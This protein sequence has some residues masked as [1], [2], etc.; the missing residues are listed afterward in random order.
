[1]SW[2]QIVF[3]TLLVAVLLFLSLFY[4]W[5]QVRALRALRQAPELPPE[6]AR[7]ERTKAWRRLVSCGLTLALA[8]LLAGLLTFLEDRAQELA[9]RREAVAAGE[10][11]PPLTPEE[12]ALARRWLW[13]WI[14][15]LLVL[16]A[17]VLL[18]AV[19][20]WA[21]RRFGLRQYRKIQADRRAM[22]ERQVSRLR[23]QRNGYR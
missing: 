9:D 7:Y 12:R 14:V 13:G 23:G 17:V 8:A 21:T 2:P 22:I 15:L 1:V 16:L 20:L 19:D 5:R 4:A 6:E 18:A 3:G 10:E 11:P